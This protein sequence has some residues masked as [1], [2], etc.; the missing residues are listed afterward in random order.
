MHGA[1]LRAA[2]RHPHSRAPARRRI[3]LATRPRR[4]ERLR[5]RGLI[6]PAAGAQDLQCLEEHLAPIGP[7]SNPCPQICPHRRS[8]PALAHHVN[9]SRQPPD[10]TTAGSGPRPGELLDSLRALRRSART[11][12]G[13]PRGV[14]RLAAPA[15]PTGGRN[16]PVRRPESPGSRPRSGTSRW[17]CRGSPGHSRPSCGHHGGHMRIIPRGRTPDRRFPT[18]LPAPP[19]PTGTPCKLATARMARPGL[20]NRLR[21]SLRTRVRI[22]PSPFHRIRPPTGADRGAA[23]SPMGQ[24]RPCPICCAWSAIQDSG[25]RID[26]LPT[27][28]AGLGA[29]GWLV[30]TGVGDT[31]F[32]WL[33][34]RGG[35]AWSKAPS[36]PPER[37]C[38]HQMRATLDAPLCPPTRVERIGRG[39]RAPCA[40][41]P[42]A[43]L[44]IP[45][46]LAMWPKS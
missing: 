18:K 6:G 38:D 35:P 10:A 14:P 3:A 21:G 9:L 2:H 4:L 8:S 27:D 43:R 29:G 11:G 31:G 36:R 44:V 25:R 1:P 13:T 37:R 7:D 45:G 15:C 17:P 19:T 32:S 40:A 12:A 23:F 41:R 30:R 33:R 5:A 28:K 34:W 26:H 39:L 42:L 20:E 46:I 16:L 24:G 22:P